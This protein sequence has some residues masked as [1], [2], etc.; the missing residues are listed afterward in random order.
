MAI[1]F[2]GLLIPKTVVL[3]QYGFS[4]F[5]GVVLDTFVVRTLLVPAVVTAFS[6]KSKSVDLNWWPYKM[7]AVILS[8]A[9]EYRALIAGGKRATY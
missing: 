4:L 9:E 1:S 5:I 8:P 7:P 6:V 3:N 2:A